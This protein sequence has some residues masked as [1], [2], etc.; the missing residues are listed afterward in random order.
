M[1]NESVLDEDKRV[2]KFESFHILETLS[3]KKHEEIITLAKGRAGQG[4]IFE[5]F[6]PEN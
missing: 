3:K 6:Q 5:I 2:E 1:K 4:S